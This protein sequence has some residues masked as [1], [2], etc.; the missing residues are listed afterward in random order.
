MRGGVAAGHHETAAA[1]RE[2]LEAGGTAFDAVLAAL[3]TACVAEPVLASLGGGGFLLA[4]P[5]DG[6]AQLFDFF[7]KTPKVKKDPAALEFDG[8]LATFAGGVT[9]EFHAGY[10]AVAVPGMIAGL[11]AVHRRYATLPMIEIAA[12]ALRRARNGVR[13]D[14]F[15][16]YVA[17]IVAPILGYSDESRAVYASPAGGLMRQG[18]LHRQPQLAD[19]IAALVAE[20]PDLFYAGDLGAALIDAC[21]QNGGY[22]TAA[23]LQDYRVTTRSPLEVELPGARILTN[24]PPA[25]GGLLVAFGLEM[26]AGRVLDRFGSDAHLEQLS[27]AMAATALARAGARDRHLLDPALLARYRAQIDDRVLARRG[28]THVSVVDGA[29]NAVAATV[30]NGS[31]AGRMI[32]ASGVMLNNMLGEQDLSPDGFHLWPE[33]T[34]MTSM[35]APTLVV[36]EDGWQAALGS[37]GSN[38][39]RSAVLQVLVNYLMFDLSLQNAIEAPRM[40]YENGRLDI[41][42]GLAPEVLDRLSLA[43]QTRWDRH[44]MF[45]GG[46]HGVAVH[47]E[48][49]MMDGGGDPRRDGVFLSL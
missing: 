39:I 44:D 29:G 8:L 40:H 26:L 43:A 21:A 30:S 17:E 4:R 27:Q 13:I 24:P 12:P 22:I 31:S 2:I 20:G 32:P 19:T 41:E 7:V 38:R 10:G 15:Q 5:A 35:M 6:G 37:G 48:R 46:V 23:D 49:G 33:D 9:Q 16:A 11:F 34:R 25:S 28:T 3:W 47:P 42:A 45:F 36:R 14:A 18:D 1:A